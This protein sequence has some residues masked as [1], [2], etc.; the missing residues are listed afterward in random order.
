MLIDGRYKIIKT[1]GKGGC[2]ETFLAEDIRL[3]SKRLCVVKHLK[4]DTND[5]ETRQII[6]DRFEREAVV[7]ESLG[8]HDQIPELYAFIEE[9]GE[10]YII[11]QYVEGKTLTQK[12]AQDGAFDAEFV[13]DFLL[14]ILPVISHIHQKGVIHRDIKPDNIILRESDGM[15]VLIDFGV[16]KEIVTTLVNGRGSSS[17]I[18]VGSKGYVSREQIMGFP[19][20]SSDLFSL[21]MTALYML[22]GKHPSTVFDITT[23]SVRWQDVPGKWNY[24]AY[25]DSNLAHFLV[26]SFDIA[27][28][29]DAEQRFK[30]AQEMQKSLFESYS[31]EDY[32]SFRG[33]TPYML[34]VE[35]SG[36]GSISAHPF[37]IIDHTQRIKGY[38]KRYAEKRPEAYQRFLNWKAIRLFEDEFQNYS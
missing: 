13:M 10:F 7:L 21:G 28:K 11:Q 35:Y 23:G 29:L 31:D 1:L 22:T 12:V 25:E 16:V 3:P 33:E 9:S 38:V 5:A 24:W 26:D 18:I 8:E 30:S 32:I 37:I 17:T 34:K 27:V 20:F 2:G 15:P 6:K 14:C 4:P 19:V 36:Y